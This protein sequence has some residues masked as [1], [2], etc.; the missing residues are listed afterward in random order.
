MSLAD[1]KRSVRLSAQHKRGTIAASAGP[2][3]H[4]LLAS[5]VMDLVLSLPAPITVSGFL[6][7]GSEI[8]LKP[9]FHR[10]GQHDITTCLP[11]V[12]EKDQPL[13]FRTWKHGEPLESGPLKTR[14]PSS[15][16]KE[17]R[18]DVLL[19][20]L[21]TYDD[22]GYRLGWGGGYYDRTLAAYNK[23]G[24]AVTAIGVAYNDQQIDRV[25]ADEMDIPMDWIVTE[26][27]ALKIMK[28]TI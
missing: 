5:H 2:N 28:A 20:P 10:L 25:P 11:V 18:P 19:V 15:L 13:V 12:L 22:R 26:S 3:A 8:D 17:V 6:S 7:I 21:L 1:E 27:R 23:A 16:A 24:W 9:C 4:E 14:H